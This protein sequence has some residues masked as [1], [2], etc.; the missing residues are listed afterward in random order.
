MRYTFYIVY[1]VCEKV[2]E[3]RAEQKRKRFRVQSGLEVGSRLTE[4]QDRVREWERVEEERYRTIGISS[5]RSTREHTHEK[6]ERKEGRSRLMMKVG[7][8]RRKKK[9]SAGGESIRIFI[10]LT[11]NITN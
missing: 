1:K 8:C 7:S 11:K 6:E 3:V 2:R 9:K 4:T 5:E 10:K